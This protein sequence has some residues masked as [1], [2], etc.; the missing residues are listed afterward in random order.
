MAQAYQMSPQAYKMGYSQQ[1]MQMQQGGGRGGEMETTVY[2]PGELVG[3]FIGAKGRAIKELQAQ[4]N[5]VFISVGKEDEVPAG[6]A[7]P[8]RPVS[9][10]GSSDAVYKAQSIIQSRY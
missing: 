9:L 4:C 5:G 7:I 2:L 1:S 6:F 8:M 3:M 10:K